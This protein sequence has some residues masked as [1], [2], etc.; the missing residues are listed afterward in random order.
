MEPPVSASC[1]P[2]MVHLEG[3][4]SRKSPEKTT[5]PDEQLLRYNRGDPEEHGMS[6]PDPADAMEERLD[7]ALA[8]FMQRRDRGEALDCDRFL[9]EHPD[10]AVPLRPLLLTF[11][12]VER[13]TAPPDFPPA[14]QLDDFEILG[15]LARGGMGVVYRARQKSLNRTVALKMIGGAVRADD[16][17]RFRLEVEA[18]VLLDHPNIVPVYEV[19]EQD[20]RPF[21]AM[22]LMEGGSLKDRLTNACPSQADAVRLVATLA[23]AV[24]HAHQHGILHR[25][26]KPAN[27]LF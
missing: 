11:A 26:L 5:A 2:G 19:G 16:L 14:A 21:Y 13:L 24:H 17:Q 22:K 25:D 27:I 18:A 20:G 6:A 15:E 3:G 23:R 7:L 8:E 12:E 9:A 10:L 4:L 1:Q